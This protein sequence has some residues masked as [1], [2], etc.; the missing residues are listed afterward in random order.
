MADRRSKKQDRQSRGDAGHRTGRFISLSAAASTFITIGLSPLVHMPV[1]KAD[2]EDII[3][4]QIINSLSAVD[5]TVALDM[6]SWLSSLDAALQGAANFDPSSLAGTMP[7]IDSALSAASTAVPAADPA[8]SSSL[9]GLYE[10]FIYDPSHA[11]DQ[12]WID[13]TTLLGGL[14]VAY[15]DF[16]NQF[17]PAGEM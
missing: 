16:I 3:I 4:D 9:A 8:A 7:A 2:G 10:T 13:G 15:D 1:A 11:F 12:R 14:T 6:S 5:P 17:A